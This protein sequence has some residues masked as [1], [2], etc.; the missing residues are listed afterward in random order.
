MDRETH[1][2]KSG[3]GS[4][5]ASQS[6]YTNEQGEKCIGVGCGLTIKLPNDGSGKVGFHADDSAA[7]CTDEER[8]FIK[9]IKNRVVEGGDT[10]YDFKRRN[11]R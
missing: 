10:E 4:K 8:D 6:V 5:R 2:E 3:S 11:R 1:D 9:Q 7:D